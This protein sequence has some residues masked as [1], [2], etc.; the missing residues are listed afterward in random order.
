[1]EKIVNIGGHDYKMKSTAANLLKYKAQFGRDLFED[2][3]RL[4]EAMLPDGTVERT[5]ASI[6]RRSIWKCCITWYGFL[7][8]PQIQNCRRRLNGLIRLIASRWKMQRAKLW[9]FMS[10]AWAAKHQKTDRRRRGHR[11]GTRSRKP[12][13]NVDPWGFTFGRARRRSG[14]LHRRK[15]T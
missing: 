13:G 2:V 9:R 12:H 11:A 6:F 14:I 3:Q 1:M 4:Q 15:L 8:R 5:E 10:R 7:S